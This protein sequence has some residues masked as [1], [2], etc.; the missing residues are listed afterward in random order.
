V[1]PT[2]WHAK[3]RRAVGPAFMLYSHPAKGGGPSLKT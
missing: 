3:K 2:L 1:A